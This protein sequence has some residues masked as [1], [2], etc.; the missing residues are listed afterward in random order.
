MKALKFIEG[1]HNETL[2]AEIYYDCE[3]CEYRVKFAAHGE[4]MPDADYHCTDLA[5]AVATAYDYMSI[6]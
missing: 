1:L 5:D 3:W 6:A 4:Y 2:S